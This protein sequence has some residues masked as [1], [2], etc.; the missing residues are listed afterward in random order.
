MTDKQESANIL[1]VSTELGKDRKDRGWK[2]LGS[3]SYLRGIEFQICKMRNSSGG[4]IHSKGSR[5]VT[6]NSTCVFLK[7]TA[8]AATTTLP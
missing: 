7:L 4:W 8:A 6:I 1:W 5:M 3:R 2:D